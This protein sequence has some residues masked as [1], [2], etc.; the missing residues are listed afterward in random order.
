M[1]LIFNSSHQKS[2]I[3]FRNQF[4]FLFHITSNKFTKFSQS[5]VAVQLMLLVW[6]LNIH[7]IN[8]SHPILSKL[9]KV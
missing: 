7:H 8:V 4:L 3:S 9:I 6:N 2:T 5:P 1:K